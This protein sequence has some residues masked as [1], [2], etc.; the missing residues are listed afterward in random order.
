MKTPSFWLWFMANE[1]TLKKLHSLSEKKREELMYWFS[2]HLDY[3]NPQIGYRLMI[4]P[5]SQELPTLAF[6]TNG[7]LEAR[8]H[9]LHLMETAPKTKDWIISATITSLAEE[10]PNY[11]EK[12]YCIE[13]VCCRQSNIK[14]WGELIDLNT[15]QL[16]LGIIFNFPIKEVQPDLLRQIISIVLIDTLGEQ[17]YDRYIKDFI[18][19]TQIPEDEDLF[20]LYE[21]KM[22]LEGL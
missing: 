15:K 3:F 14:F 12:E 7:D 8:K 6:T 4:P 11:Y 18:I 22:Y 10:D 21:L 5:N 1:K 16:V 2:T 19:Y 20:E 17:L 9:I 13:G